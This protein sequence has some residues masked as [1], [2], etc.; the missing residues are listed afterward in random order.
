MTPDELRSE[1]DAA[2]AAGWKYYLEEI[3]ISPRRVRASTIK[4]LDCN[5]TIT[6]E[7]REGDA[8]QFATRLIL[9]LATLEQ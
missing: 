5:A 8:H 7:L 3:E 4:S 6:I 1:L 2:Y 9:A